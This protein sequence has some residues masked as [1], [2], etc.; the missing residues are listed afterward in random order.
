[1]LQVDTLD[2]SMNNGNKYQLLCAIDVFSR[3]VFVRAVKN[4]RDIA[5]RMNVILSDKQPIVLQT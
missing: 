4:R 3:K 2:V 1:M 5:D